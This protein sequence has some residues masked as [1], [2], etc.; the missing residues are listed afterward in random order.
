MIPSHVLEDYAR[1]GGD[2]DLAQYAKVATESWS[3]IDSLLMRLQIVDAGY[4][5]DSF[6]LDFMRDIEEAGI[7]LDRLRELKK[8]IDNADSDRKKRKA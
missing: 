3:G 6:R 7:P 4:A 2:C 5:A 1:L 8:Q